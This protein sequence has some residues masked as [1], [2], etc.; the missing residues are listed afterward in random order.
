MGKLWGIALQFIV[1]FYS[2]IFDDIVQLAREKY[3]QSTQFPSFRMRSFW[4]VR[5]NATR[6][7]LKCTSFSFALFLITEYDSDTINSI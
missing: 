1:K 5:Y 6:K 2:S 4:I 3:S 7:K